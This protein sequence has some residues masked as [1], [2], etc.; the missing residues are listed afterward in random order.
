[1]EKTILILPDG[2]Q[3]HSGVPGETAL[4]QVQLTENINDKKTLE[5]GT[6]AASVLQCDLL[7][8]V[9]PELSAGTQVTVLREDAAGNSTKT[10]IFFSQGA[11]KMGAGQYRLTLA[12]TVSLLDRDLTGWLEGLTGWPYSL[13]EF[14]ELICHACGVEVSFGKGLSGDFPVQKF[15][16][17]NVTGRALMGWV[18]QAA[19][20]FCRADPEGVLQ[21][22]WYEDRGRQV[23]A[24]GETD[25]YYQ[26]SL[27]YEQFTVPPVERVV[28]RQS[29]EDVG[30]SWPDTADGENVLTLT[31]NPL[32]TGEDTGALQAVARNLYERLQGFSYTP[33]RLTVPAGFGASV[34]EL[35]TVRTVSGE[36]FTAPVMSRQ[37][38]GGKDVVQCVGTKVR[39]SATPGS[40]SYHALTG[41][42]LELT[43]NMDGLRAENRSLSGKSAAIEM[44]VE[45]M[46]AEVSRQEQSMA[47]IRQ[48]VTALQQTADQVKFSV[49]SIAENGVS[50][51][52]T[53]TGY[54]FGEDGLRIQKSGQEMENKLTDTG[55]YVSRGGTAML[56]ADKDG[57]VATD[58]S[59]RNYLIIGSHAR[60][61]DYS[62]GADAKRTACYW[63]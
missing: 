48:E 23:S 12:D 21:L 1:M 43:A 6:V 16:A 13:R 30:V 42:V 8:E 54:T 59:V 62:D 57:V 22:D 17:T 50:R 26:N 18:C 2:R 47:G 37:R 7:G 52:V 60:L 11:E 34:G 29:R 49:E 58:V 51:V 33:C 15:A 39:E 46:T 53:S 32:L 20:V 10:G 38:A 3:L 24:H 44:T 28:L 56:Q 19:G 63:I 35:L 45:G 4:A 41:K 55:M 25:F 36:S 9:L 40:L 5:P 27:S 31:A 61:E 14:A